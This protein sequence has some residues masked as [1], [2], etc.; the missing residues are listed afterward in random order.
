LINNHRKIIYFKAKLFI[1]KQNYL[2]QSK[3]IYFKAKLFISSGKISRNIK[4][5]IKTNTQTH[6]SKQRR[7]DSNCQINSFKPD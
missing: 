5:A 1:S 3:I 7:K 4:T 2:F 6:L